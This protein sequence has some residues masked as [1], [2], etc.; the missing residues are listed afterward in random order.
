MNK[1]CKP[2]GIF[3][4][5]DLYRTIGYHGAN[6]VI[7]RHYIR[8]IP[9]TRLCIGTYISVVREYKVFIGTCTRRIMLKY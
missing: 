1:L 5:T 7:L 6:R 4:L 9:T 3:L 2:G 8:T